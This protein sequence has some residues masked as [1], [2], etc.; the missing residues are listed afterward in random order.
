MLIWKNTATLDGYDEGLHFTES[1]KGADI[2]LLGSKPI[3]LIEFPNL[4]GIFRAGIGSDNVP[5]KEAK[6]RGIIVRFPSKETIDIIFEETASFTCSFI[7]RM[8]FS[9]IGTIDPWQ[10]EPRLQIS[11]K[12]LLVIGAGRIGG[13]VAELIKHFMRVTT[14]DILQN[15]TSELKPLMQEADCVTVHIPKS[16][17][18]ISFIDAEKLSW[19]KNGS[20][21]INTARGA[22]VDE[23][24]L[25]KELEIGRLKAAFDVY[26]HEPYNGKLKTID[27]DYFY[28]TPHV[29]STC[30]GFLEG[31]RKDIN[32]LI[33]RLN[34]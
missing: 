14:F 5:V 11:K 10:K 22:I 3:N 26:W 15:E 6:E 32:K 24:A 2:A 33:L 16:D 9:N 25:Y 1:K 4:K 34:K 17:E 28:M 18:N 8:L 13:R 20:S 19:M 30:S 12:R 27:P 29:A 21:L 23:D 31:C 7:F